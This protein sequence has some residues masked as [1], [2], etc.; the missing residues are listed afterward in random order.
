MDLE[1]GPAY[2]S[3]FG[4]YTKDWIRLTRDLHG[5]LMPMWKYFYAKT[6]RTA[7]QHRSG[8]MLLISYDVLKPMI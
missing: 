1:A 2:T 3:D 5:C 4:G 6:L 7:V 8:M